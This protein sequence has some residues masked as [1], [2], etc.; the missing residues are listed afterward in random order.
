MIAQM[1]RATAERVVARLP[2]ASRFPVGRLV[3]PVGLLQSSVRSLGEL[4]LALRPEPR[5]L[6]GLNLERLADWIE[7]EVGDPVAAAEVRTT[8]AAAP[9]YVEACQ[10]IYQLVHDRVALAQ[11]VLGSMP[12]AAASGPDAR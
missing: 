11:E 2:H 1:D 5:S 4:E 7:Q 6:A 10:A 9:S 12:A 3:P 8:T